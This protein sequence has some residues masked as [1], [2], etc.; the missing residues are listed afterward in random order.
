MQWCSIRHQ[1]TLQVSLYETSKINWRH[2]A[3]D[4]EYFDTKTHLPVKLDETFH[5]INISF[6]FSINFNA[7][8]K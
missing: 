8:K 3:A 1:I 6:A 5:N 7:F 2:V 4:S